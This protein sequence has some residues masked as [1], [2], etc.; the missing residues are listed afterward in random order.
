[1]RRIIFA[2]AAALLAIG[3]AVAAPT[4]QPQGAAV[5]PGAEA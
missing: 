5:Q 3:P 4:I 1:M 2:A